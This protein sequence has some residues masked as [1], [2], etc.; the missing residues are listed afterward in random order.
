MGKGHFVVLVGPDGV[1]KTALAGQLIADHGHPSMYVHFRPSL[2]RRPPDAPNEQ[3][4]PS[5]KRVR[6]GPRM[7][8]WIRLARSVLLFWLGYLRWIRPAVLRG[9][10]VVG[11]RWAYGYVGQ[12]QALGFAGPAWLAKLGARIVPQPDLLVRLSA[13]PE[14]VAS[15]KA[16][17]TTS[18]VEI[19]ARVWDTLPLKVWE[20]DASMDISHL[21]HQLATRLAHRK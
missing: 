2:W 16:D 3:S 6:P 10:L 14:L 20:L 8:G 4:V 15:R 17:L 13:P 7:L 11:D 1:G 18:E 19:E 5:P 21:A 12:P 9:A